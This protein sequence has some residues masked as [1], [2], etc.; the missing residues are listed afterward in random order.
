LSLSNKFSFL[1]LAHISASAG[2]LNFFFL[3]SLIPELFKRLFLLPLLFPSF[4]SLRFF[5]SLKIIMGIYEILG[6]KENR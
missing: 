1:L 6:T 5:L 3:L 2:I 4:N